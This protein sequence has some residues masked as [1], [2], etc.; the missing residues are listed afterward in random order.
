LEISREKFD[1]AFE[2]A[3]VSHGPSEDG[4]AEEYKQIAVGL[5]RYLEES[6]NGLKLYRPPELRFSILGGEVVITP[7]QVV[8]H[9]DGQ[10]IMR[11]VRTGHR[12][13]KEKDGV[14]AAV[15]HLAATA[16]TPGCKVE[17]VHLGDG[18]VTPIEMSAKV[19]GNRQATLKIIADGLRAGQFPLNEDMVCPRC[20]AFFV[21]GRLPSGPLV[22]KFSS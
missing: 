10:V 14:A 6:T 1:A 20:P 2:E 11:K 3:W 9:P 5:I 18:E 21:C 13:D 15:F 17:L 19:L 7:D 16:H 4:Y 8:S 12:S 22:K